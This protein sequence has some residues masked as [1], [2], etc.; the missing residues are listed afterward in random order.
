MR[1]QH[2]ALVEPAHEC[3]SRPQVSRAAPI[4]EGHEG[5][6]RSD[7]V[8]EDG[9]DDRAERDP[10]QGR[11]LLH[12]EHPC[13]HGLI[14]RALEQRPAAHHHHGRGQSG[15]RERHHGGGEAAR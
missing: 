8:D 6:R 5:R 14:G 10:E 11:S 12:G 15:H 13:E 3:G 1:S 9:G 4:A 2:S 7:P